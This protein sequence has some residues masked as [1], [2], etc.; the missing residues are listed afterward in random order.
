MTFLFTST[1][2][3]LGIVERNPQTLGTFNSLDNGF[4]TIE[5][6]KAPENQG[7]C[8]RDLDSALDGIIDLATT[9]QCIASNEEFAK[10]GIDIPNCPTTDNEGDFKGLNHSFPSA[11]IFGMYT[12][13]NSSFLQDLIQEYISDNPAGK[14]NLVL[15]RPF[16]GALKDD[17]SLTRLLNNK[18]VNIIQVESFPSVERWMQD[19]FEFGSLEGKPALYQLEHHSER[20]RDFEGR[21]ACAI[22]KSCDVPYLVPPDMVDPANQEVNSLNSGGNLETMPGGTIYRGIIKSEGFTNWHVPGGNSIPYETNTQKVQRESLEKSGNRVLD[23]DTSFLQ[24]GHVD[25]IINIVQTNKPAPCNF[26]VMLASPEKAFELMEAAGASSSPAAPQQAPA[27]VPKGGFIKTIESL[28]ISEAHAGAVSLKSTTAKKED[29]ACSEVRYNNLW[30]EGAESAVSKERV[31]E[32]YSMNCIDD[33]SVSTF[34]ESDE[35]QILKTAN[36]E[37]YEPD[38]PSIS[39]VMRNNKEALLRELSE[40]SGCKSPPI[41]DVPVF[42]RDG[43]SYAPDLVNGVVH[44][45]SNNTSSIIM[46][47]SYFRPFDDYMK[48]ELKK[49]GVG[50]TFVHGVGYHQLQGQVHCGT[51][52]ARI[53]K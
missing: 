30:D 16:I 49:I 8:G 15:P 29:R 7:A 50:A 11:G 39:Q 32:I 53:C 14:F 17:Q 20:G 26:A 25:E 18:R 40:T 45:N 10:S 23:L 42:F 34:I 41:I 12:G 4:G 35:Y 52:T 27:P 28:L 51:N 46:P 43:V 22:A 6:C 47:R 1:T 37:G 36:L 3:S 9:N 33:Q 48:R 21:L 19:S 44:T 31:E 13:N 5:E 24:V 2:Y 38:V